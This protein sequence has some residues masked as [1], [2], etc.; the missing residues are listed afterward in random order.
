MSN[1]PRL[2]TLPYVLLGAMSVASFGGP[3]LIVAV[4]SGGASARW[5]PDRPVEWWVIT[6]VCGL[7]T[8]LFV[9]CVS[10]SWWYGPAGPTTGR[11]TGPRGS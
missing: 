2:P 8:A 5:P 7:V 3:F 10:L 6:V 9:A 1:N 4:L 11:G